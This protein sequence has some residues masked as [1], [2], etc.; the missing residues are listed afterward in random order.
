MEVFASVPQEKILGVVINHVKP[1]FLWRA[2]ASSYYYADRN[3]DQ[4]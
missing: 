4:N 1:W 3:A 2:A